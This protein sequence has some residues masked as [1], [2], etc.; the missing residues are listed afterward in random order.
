MKISDCC[1]DYR[2]SDALEWRSNIRT[3]I[4]TLYATL[5]NSDRNALA[6]AGHSFHASSLLFISWSAESNNKAH[7]GNASSC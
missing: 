5:T 6:K 4:C 2:T 1:R 3:C 7:E